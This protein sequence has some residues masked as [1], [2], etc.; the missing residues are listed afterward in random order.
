MLAGRESV[1]CKQLRIGVLSSNG[2]ETG[3][4]PCD[5]CIPASSG[6][7]F[8]ETVSGC[9]S[10]DEFLAYSNDHIRLIRGTGINTEML[11][12]NCFVHIDLAPSIGD[13]DAMSFRV[14]CKS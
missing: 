13:I 11:R 10:I 7:T 4:R 8:K 9:N 6:E 2:A 3:H 14:D 12:S 1:R 5:R